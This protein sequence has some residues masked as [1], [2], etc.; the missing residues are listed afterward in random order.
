MRGEAVRQDYMVIRSIGYQGKWCD[1]VKGQ[2]CKGAMV[3]RGNGNPVTAQLETANIHSHNKLGSVS[4]FDR[5]RLQPVQC[6]SVH[7]A[8]DAGNLS[9]CRM[10]AGTPCLFHTVTPPVIG[11]A[12]ARSRVAV[13][14]GS[15]PAAFRKFRLRR[16]VSQTTSS[17]RGKPR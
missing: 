12:K 13:S 10:A 4:P 6:A 14:I 3:Q 9:A 5:E 7:S 15:V 16:A 2:W 1:G 11:P 8:V 17:G